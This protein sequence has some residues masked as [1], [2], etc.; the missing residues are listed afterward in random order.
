MA[1]ELIE[2]ISDDESIGSEAPALGLDQED[3]ESDG[4]VIR[5]RPTARAAA[6]GGTSGPAGLGAASLPQRPPAEPAQPPLAAAA[7]RQPAAGAVEPASPASA[8]SDAEGSMPG[9]VEDADEW[10][11]QESED[12]EAAPGGK[13]G[14]DEEPAPGLA[15]D[16]EDEPPPGL[17]S[18]DDSVLGLAGD[19]PDA[20]S[21]ERWCCGGADGAARRGA[22]RRR[23]AA[24]SNNSS[25]SS[26]SS[27]SSAAVPGGKS[28]QKPAEPA[29]ASGSDYDDDVP[30]LLSDASGDESQGFGDD[31]EDEG[32][33]QRRG[34][35]RGATPAAA[36][37]SQPYSGTGAGARENERADRKRQ[38][39]EERA[40]AAKARRARAKAAAQ[41]RAARGRRTLRTTARADA[42]PRDA[43]L[44]PAGLSALLF[45]PVGARGAALPLPHPLPQSTAAS[46]EAFEAKDLDERTLE[47][48]REDEVTVQDEVLGLCQ[49]REQCTRDPE[50][51]EVRTSHPDRYNIRCSAG[52]DVYWHQAC[53]RKDTVN[54]DGKLIKEDLP[55][56]IPGCSG[57]LTFALG[58]NMYELIK[59]MSEEV[60]QRVQKK[61]KEEQY[62]A[63]QEHARAHDRRH[64]GKK[65]K[66]WQ[67]K[68]EE[69]AGKAGP[70]EAEE[71]EQAAA[72]P[73]EAAAAE[74]E[75]ATEAAASQ[76]AEDGARAGAEPA[77]PAGGQK[78]S[79]PK[80][81]D[82]EVAL[83]DSSMLRA[84]KRESDDE[85]G[86]LVVGRRRRDKEKGK[87]PAEAEVVYEGA[88]HDRRRKKG[89]TLHISEIQGGAASLAEQK[90]REAAEEQAVL[91]SGTPDA[92]VR[93]VGINLAD[94]PDLD[95]AARLAAEKRDTERHE[96]VRRADLLL[97]ALRSLRTDHDVVSTCILV[98]AIDY[99]KIEE[100]EAASPEQALRALLGEFGPLGEVALFEEAGAAVVDYLQA[101]SAVQASM[102]LTNLVYKNRRLRLLYLCN[103]PSAGELEAIVRGLEEEEAARAQPA[104]SAA[105][106]ADEAGP[107]SSGGASSSAGQRA[108]RV[109]EPQGGSRAASQ[110]IT[111]RG[112]ASTS[113]SRANGLRP[114]S[115]E[116][117]PSPSFGSGGSSGAGSLRPGAAAFTPPGGSVG[118]G[119]SGQ[120]AVNAPEFRPPGHGGA[121]GE[122]PGEAPQEGPDEMEEDPIVDTYYS[123]QLV[124]VTDEVWE[125]EHVGL[126]SPAMP[127]ALLLY[128]TLHQCIYGVWTGTARVGGSREGAG[129]A[130]ERAPRQSGGWGPGE[131]C[132]TQIFH[133][134]REVGVFHRE[135]LLR[136]LPIAVAAPYIAQW[137]AT[138]SLAMPRMPQML[139]AHA[140]AGLLREFLALEP[141]PPRPPPP[142]AAAAGSHLRAASRP[143]QPPPPTVAAAAAIAAASR[144]T[145]GLR[146]SSSRA[147]SSAGLA[148]SAP[149]G[150]GSTGAASTAGGVSEAAESAAPAAP[151]ARPPAAREEAQESEEEERRWREEQERADA[152]LARK[153]QES[154]AAAAE[155]Q[156]QREEGDAALVARLAEAAR[157]QAAAAAQPPRPASGYAAAAAWPPPPGARPGPGPDLAALLPG[158]RP[159]AVA[160]PAEAGAAALVAAPPAELAAPVAAPSR[161]PV[162]PLAAV[163]PHL[164]LPAAGPP[165]LAPAAGPPHL[166]P[167]AGPP[168]LAPAAGPPHLAP[169]A[170]PPPSSPA[171]T[172]PPGARPAP[173]RPGCLSDDLSVQEKLAQ[174]P[175]CLRCGMNAFHYIRVYN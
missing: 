72:D 123:G 99:R 162:Q 37:P 58:P 88:R 151:D 69:P 79:P 66:G 95:E 115:S 29:K 128:H 157:R 76:A 160:P 133:G 20:S 34:T 71:S 130:E 161:A 59:D 77:T 124:A 149:A 104:A 100:E 49:L 51:Y 17:S 137:D 169:T 89:T 120:W 50:R 15:S 158:Y 68:W 117:V 102:G 80:S 145:N 84:L 48:L 103:M 61:H 119:G 35:Q 87:A 114:T 142:R 81:P 132:R 23:A 7:P 93:N 46:A 14:G 26:S 31:S 168:H 175:K 10:G 43:S 18:N 30:E 65:G 143:A 5:A 75:Q 106:P 155:A 131:A 129:A 4:D 138:S 172:R 121:P 171:G 146:Q 148:P 33:Q 19:D 36:R 163:L 154:E 28:A 52:H 6:A 90:R 101:N 38:Q 63:A 25:S 13:S 166:A 22:V 42:P 44:A 86:L 53:W 39:E 27:S 170:G 70:A 83:P 45:T 111:V 109:L 108:P 156:R 126:M 85:D 141:P 32:G 67:A 3:A 105:A 110:P 94:F 16:D 74:A 82:V 73:E 122:A 41:A 64:R 56:V 165:H 54:A 91:D 118:G 113:S 136:P 140:V 98:E 127:V 144:A 60:A 11:S 116:F 78:A 40:A 152:E 1:S 62:A 21:R 139:P 159:P 112:S 9:L 150:S 125:L 92:G 164:A 2:E 57:T 173:Y 12:D 47:Q 97:S 135:R 24:R 134:A 147:E 107:S 96:R 8:P 174:F 153:M 55:C 167:A